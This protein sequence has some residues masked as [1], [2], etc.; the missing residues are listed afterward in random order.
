MVLRSVAAVWC[1]VSLSIIFP[2]SHVIAGGPPACMPPSCG[3]APV[4]CAPQT[5]G[6][7]SCGSGGSGL[8][9]SGC[10]GICANICGAVIGCPAFI[11][12][13]LL[14]PAPV[15]LPWGSGSKCGPP[16]CAPVSCA[17]PMCGPPVCAP[18]MCAPPICAPAPITKCK[19]VSCQPTCGASPYQ[20]AACAPPVPQCGPVASAPGYYAG[21]ASSPMWDLASGIFSPLF[22]GNSN[23]TGATW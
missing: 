3:P 13:C 9:G 8:L 6:P 23:G 16:P 18:P 10:F 4:S 14:A 15:G 7:P 5:C 2:I 1:L 11:M 22:G 21:G 20:P 17:P 12:S 19:P